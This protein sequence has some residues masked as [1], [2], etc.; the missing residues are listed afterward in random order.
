VS[1]RLGVAVPNVE[2]EVPIGHAAC[3]M[4]IEDPVVTT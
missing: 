1:V 3:A 4:H 2:R